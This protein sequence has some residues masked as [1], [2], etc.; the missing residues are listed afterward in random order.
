MNEEKISFSPLAKYF[1]RRFSFEIKENKEE[2][3]EIFLRL[4][5]EVEA[6]MD[7]GNTLLELKNNKVPLLENLIISE[8]QA[9]EGK[10]A[11]LVLGDKFIQLYKLWA[12]EKKLAFNLEKKS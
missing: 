12:S 11:P 1:W 10:L 5:T 7:L 8:Q 3:E 2:K 9:K 6:S 4:F